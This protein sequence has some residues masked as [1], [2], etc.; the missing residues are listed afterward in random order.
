MNTKVN[1]SQYRTLINVVAYTLILGGL[2][3]IGVMSLTLGNAKSDWVDDAD[4]IES[5]LNVVYVEQV[6]YDRSISDGLVET[7]TL[8]GVTR[9]DCLVLEDVDSGGYVIECTDDPAPSVDDGLG[10]VGGE[11]TQEDP[12]KGKRR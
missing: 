8:D 6:T 7:L 1:V 9:P 3:A 5:I 10:P 12:K 11:P 2:V 4:R